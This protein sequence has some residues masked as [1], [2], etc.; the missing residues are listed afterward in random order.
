MSGGAPTR[1]L[2]K[3]KRE[4][5]PQVKDKYPFLY[6]ER[7]R[8]EIDD[9]SV[10]WIDS[11]GAVIRLPC[12]MLQCLL[13]GPG[14]SVTHE[15]VKVLAGC[16]CLVAWVGED[17]LLFYATGISPTADSRNFRKQITLATHPDKA[18]EMARALFAF[19]FGSGETTGKSITQLRGMEGKRV[20]ALYAAYAEQ[21][22]VGWKGR[23]YTPGK[24]QLSDIT[25]QVLTACNA[26]M[27][28]I[29]TSCIVA[30]GYSPHVGFIH[31]GSPL[32]FT[33]DI[34][35]LYKEHMC[36]ET[37]FALTRELA[38]EYDRHV[39]SEAFR[40]KAV[41][42]DLL[43]QISSDLTKLMGG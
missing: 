5:L 29:A 26:A 17:G 39:V 35:D 1:L 40:K 19:R 25:N 23:S 28:G 36:I 9:S 37:A 34:A 32:P 31:T 13:L 38:G 14:T 16:N 27:Y 15:A 21:Y 22:G 12:A 10:K 24:F 4:T 41:E 43:G 42:S 7:G 6:L 11:E 18:A 30:M 20:K 33:Y 3:L 8:L 2:I